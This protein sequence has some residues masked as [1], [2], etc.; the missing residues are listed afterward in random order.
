MLIETEETPNPN[1]LK[2][3]PGQTVMPPGMTAEWTDEAQAQD[4]PLASTLFSVEGVQTIFYSTNFIAITK[5]EA[6]AWQDLKVKIM[7]RIM[8][9]ALM[10]VPFYEAPATDAHKPHDDGAPNAEDDEITKQIK[11]L[12]DERVRPMVAMDG[13][14][15]T[16]DR[17]DKG[18][19]Y[20][21]MRG[22]CA[23]CPSATMT[24]KSGIENMM[25][26]YVPE[27]LEVRQVED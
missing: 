20:L 4:N 13:G 12:L 22:A 27:V 23:G 16:F 9:H 5:D 18:I 8:D 15:I 24:L 19:L 26:H 10:G 14:D 11:A 3:L 6:T 25:H 1:T 2:F 7:S 17:F 21:K